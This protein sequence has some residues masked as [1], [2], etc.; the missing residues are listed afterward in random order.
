MKRLGIIAAF[1]ACAGRAAVPGLPTSIEVTIVDEAGKAVPGAYVVAREF[2]YIG[3]FHGHRVTCTRGDIAAPGAAV[4]EMRLP[5]AGIGHLS[6]GRTHSLE[7]AAYAPGYCIGRSPATDKAGNVLLRATAAPP[8]EARLHRLLLTAN[9]VAC[10]EWSARSRANV[11]ALAQAMRAEA[12]A[13]ARTRYEKSLAQRL[14]TRLAEAAMLGPSD[15][16]ISPTVASFAQPFVRD[17]VVLPEGSMVRFPSAGEPNQMV[18]A[19]T[20]GT[21]SVAASAAAP[22]MPGPGSYAAPVPPPGMIAVKPPPAKPRL[23]IRCRHGAANACD[24]DERDAQGGTALA[25]YA[26]DLNV[27]AVELLVAAGANPSIASPMPGADAIEAWMRRIMNGTVVAGSPDAA[28]A[29]AVID[30]LAASP[31]ATLAPALKAD[32]ASDPSQWRHAPPSALLLHARE[33]LAPVPARAE[34][35]RACD[36]IQPIGN[37][38]AVR[39]R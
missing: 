4:H 3:Q 5:P 22:A 26:S 8:D 14:A 37:T 12:D 39:L 18:V 21:A 6:P 1:V 9:A 27:E 11:Q 17:F 30:A 36:A 33:V 16:S 23:E 10:N 29:A 28:R 7:A 2:A 13:I 24:L 31:K 15:A 38:P 35:S 32:L 34:A 19:A 25:Q 20:R